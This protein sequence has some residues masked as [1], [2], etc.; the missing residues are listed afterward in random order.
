MDDV[1]P[2]IKHSVRNNWCGDLMER[3]GWLAAVKRYNPGLHHGINY[4]LLCRPSRT[5][6]MRKQVA[7]PGGDS[8]QT[9]SFRR[10]NFV[11]DTST[12][13]RRLQQ[14]CWS[15]PTGCS[16]G[17]CFSPGF[18]TQQLDALFVSQTQK[19][20]LINEKKELKL[21]SLLLDSCTIK[22]QNQTHSSLYIKTN[23]LNFMDVNLRKW[24]SW[25]KTHEAGQIIKN[26]V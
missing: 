12:P 20:A 21:Q 11:T 5:W 6:G 19:C 1:E 24:H 18:S 4:P 17:I 23:N 7:S 26:V 22:H 9:I 10:M 25:E 8:G 15:S 2:P 14:S 13:R 3:C 16:S